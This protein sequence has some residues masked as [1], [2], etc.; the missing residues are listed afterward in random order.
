MRVLTRQHTWTITHARRRTNGS[1]I[2]II[3]I[4]FLFIHFSFSI[5]KFIKTASCVSRA[6]SLPANPGNDDSS[7][8]NIRNLT[9]Q[10]NE[11]S[12]KSKLK[13]TPFAVCDIFVIFSP[14]IYIYIYIYCFTVRE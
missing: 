9:I 3:I 2:T 7:Y 11:D 5:A 1:R 8:K 12:Y 14:I 6:L 10:R 13:V 4:Y